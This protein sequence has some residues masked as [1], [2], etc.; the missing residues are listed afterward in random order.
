MLQYERPIH[1]LSRSTSAIICVYGTTKKSHIMYDSLLL[2]RLFNRDPVVAS[3][4][5]F[6]ALKCFFYPGHSLTQFVRHCAEHYLSSDHEE[7]RMEAVRTCSCL[8][9]PSLRVRPSSS[10][11]GVME[12]FSSFS[13]HQSGKSFN[14]SPLS[15]MAKSFYCLKT[16]YF[17]ANPSSHPLSP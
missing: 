16:H 15:S 5:E 1:W 17:N 2:C 4:R 9:T 12:T 6:M 8:L 11:Q 3:W 14:L 10:F 7:I 13:I